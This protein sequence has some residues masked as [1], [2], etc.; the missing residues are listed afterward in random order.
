ML[1]RQAPHNPSL[2]TAI[3]PIRISELHRNGFFPE[4]LYGQYVYFRTTNELVAY[5][6]GDKVET[7]EEKKVEPKKIDKTEVEEIKVEK[8]DKEKQLNKYIPKEKKKK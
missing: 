3:D 4:Y 2:Y 8:V 5:L 6:N 7:K 1:K